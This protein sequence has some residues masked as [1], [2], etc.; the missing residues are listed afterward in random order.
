M[1]E[2]KRRSTKKEKEEQEVIKET[3]VENNE[4]QEEQE[5]GTLAQVKETQ[6]ENN[7]NSKD[8]GKTGESNQL[9]PQ[10][11]VV[12]PPKVMVEGDGDTGITPEEL[13]K[14]LKP[15]KQEDEETEAPGKKEPTKEELFQ[16]ALVDC[17][18]T[19]AWMSE[20]A[21]RE[22]IERLGLSLESRADIVKLFSDDII[23]LK[24]KFREF[25]RRFI[26]NN[27]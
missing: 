21:A 24:M 27:K 8:Q 26:Q 25:K 20:A 1:A 11:V 17:L 13:S 16:T 22:A 7:E 10:G 15:T 23:S 12:E 4:N 5:M 6:I 14:I 9:P 18:I 3:K 2:R 19:R